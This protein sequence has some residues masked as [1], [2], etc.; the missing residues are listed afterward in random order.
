MGKFQRPQNQKTEQHADRNTRQCAANGC[1]LCGTQSHSIN[2][3]AAWF[4]EYHYDASADDSETITKRIKENRE[5][6]MELRAIAQTN[7][8]SNEILKRRSE[9]WRAIK[10]TPKGE[11]GYF[12]TKYGRGGNAVA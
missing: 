8:H 7:P 2:G 1:P 5:L 6:F 10:S 4:C 3:G 12:K 9:L 11:G